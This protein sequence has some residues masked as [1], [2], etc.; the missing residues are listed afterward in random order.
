MSAI[1]NPAVDEVPSAQVTRLSHEVVR[2]FG[3]ASRR[4]RQTWHDAEVGWFRLSSLVPGYARLWRW[5]AARILR[6][7]RALSWALRAIPLGLALGTSLS[8]DLARPPGEGG[9]SL[10]L[11]PLPPELSKAKSAEEKKEGPREVPWT[12]VLPI[13]HGVRADQSGKGHF[14]APRFHGEHNGLDL[15]APVGTPTFSACDGQARA[16]VSRSFGRWVHLICPV[17]EQLVKTGG[18]AP[19]ASF[20]YAHLDQLELEHDKWVGVTRGQKLGTVG[21]T[22]NSRGDSVQPHLHL[23]LIV[24]KNRRSAMD[25]R[26]LGN[27]QSL[28]SAAEYFASA[29]ED[30]CLEPY[31][32]QAKSRKILRARRVDPFLALVCLSP[33]KPRFEKAPEPLQFASTAWSDLYVAKDFNVNSS[34]GVARKGR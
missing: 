6:E 22:G 7:T 31:G 26:H 11:A 4:A 32:F 13:D 1:V 34:P 17:P 3:G 30:T 23:E 28:V 5:K 10:M 21:K 9:D 2:G 29:L 14:R 12:Y 15:L 16:G 24:Q 27:D 19:W 18:P 33:E 25:E 20:F 8:C